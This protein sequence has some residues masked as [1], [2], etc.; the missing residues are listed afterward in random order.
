MFGSIYFRYPEMLIQSLHQMNDA[1]AQSFSSLSPSKRILARIYI[2]LFGIPEVGFQVRGMYFRQALRSIE[3]KTISSALDIGSG[4]GCYVF[5]MAHMYPRSRIVGY[6]ID[7]DKLRFANIVKKDL[8]MKNCSFEYGNIV[9]NISQHN[10]F[11]FASIVDVLEHIKDYKRALRHIYK[12]LIP[13]GYIYIHVPQIQQK[14]FFSTFN[15][16]EHEDHVREGFDPVIFAKD[17]Q[18]IGF[19][20]VSIRN[21]F[22]FFGS[23]A[24]E[25]NHLALGQSQVVSVL[26]YP[27][28]YI[29]SLL[30]ILFKNSYG[31]GMAVVAQKI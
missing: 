25:L 1:Y 21:T 8:K 10:V 2:F 6:E 29:L 14:R 15:S 16:W 22:G 3:N 18:K 5:H 30:D 12:F 27:F 19:R 28:L 31:L 7:R 9:E 23:L 13:K 4:I 20:V 26:I 24:W 11:D 17:L